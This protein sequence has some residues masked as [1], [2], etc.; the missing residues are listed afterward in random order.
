[1]SRIA[2]DDFCDWLALWELAPWGDQR[3]D[4]RQEVMIL[5]TLAP[6]LKNQQKWPDTR[7][8]YWE[9]ETI[10]IELD[11]EASLEWYDR[12]KRQ[13]EE[14]RVIEEVKGLL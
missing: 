2:W 14:E 3:A 11:V 9:S 7:Y 1:M 13:L 8:P 5:A 10:R 6:W 4:A 12:H